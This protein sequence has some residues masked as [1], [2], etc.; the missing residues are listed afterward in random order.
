MAFGLH[1]KDNGT[2][3]YKNI[4]GF[5]FVLSFTISI[6]LYSPTFLSHFHQSVYFQMVPRKCISLLQG[7]SLQAVRFGLVILGEILNNKKGADL[8]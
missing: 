3:K 6:V 4:V 2:K 7:R 1:F 5:F 8:F